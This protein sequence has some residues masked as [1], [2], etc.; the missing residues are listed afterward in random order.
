MENKRLIFI[1]GGA[2]SGKSS[3][4]EQY[5]ASLYA[6][7]NNGKLFYIATSKPTDDEMSERI[8][9]HQLQR[10]ESELPWETV[11]CPVD[12]MT[13]AEHFRQEDIVL[14]DC[15][16]V[17]LTNELFREG[18]REHLLKKKGCQQN[19]LESILN[20]IVAIQN[21]SKML[22]VVSN[23]VLNEPLSNQSLVKIYG[24]LL[25]KLHQHIVKKASEAYLVE[26]GLPILMKG[27]LLDEGDNDSRNCLQCREKPD[28]DCNLPNTCKRWVSCCP[29]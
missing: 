22:L 10:Q 27:A 8:S 23:E 18:S 3:F 26:A 29:V 28:H 25:G 1:T 12:L 4:A 15:L 21:R 24:R 2:R 16:T 14:L 6:R 7:T 5:A 9:R 19:V 13:V 11:E 17:L 20:G